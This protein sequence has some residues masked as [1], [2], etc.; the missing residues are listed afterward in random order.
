MAA[1]GAATGAA[2]GP[3]GAV[4]GGGVGLLGGLISGL[5]GAS[6]EA[7]QRKA[8]RNERIEQAKR[9]AQEDWQARFAAIN[10]LNSDPMYMALS[11]KPFD[12]KEA[13]REA[14][15][16][17]DLAM[18]E[19]PANYGALI[20]SLGQAAGAVGGLVRADQLAE[21]ALA[22]QQQNTGNPW[23]GYANA[24]PGGYAALEDL[25]SP[26]EIQDWMR[27]RQQGW[28]NRDMY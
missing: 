25:N 6:D 3:V 27:S 11:Y 15:R 19:Q 7:K 26:G 23:V 22:M 24:E 5:M 21:R 9:A 2:F 20:G 4:I 28:R 10:G 18:P 1:G 14:Q 12:P 17:T 16:Y 8:V 13:E